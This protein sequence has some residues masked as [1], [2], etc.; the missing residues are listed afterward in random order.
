MFFFFK[1]IS[2]EWLRGLCLDIEGIYSRILFIDYGYKA[3]IGT[4]G[5]RRMRDRFLEIPALAVPCIVNCHEKWKDNPDLGNKIQLYL[6]DLIETKLKNVNVLKV[7]GG[8]YTISINYIE[9][10]INASEVESSELFK[11]IKSQEL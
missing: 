1:L 2:G 4:F 11:F 3:D 9:R 8:I 10:L 6:K 5:I 7:E